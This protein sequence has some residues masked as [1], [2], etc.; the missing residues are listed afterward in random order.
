MDRDASPGGELAPGRSF[1][2][3]GNLH[4]RCAVFGD[5]G[6]KNGV[7]GLPRERTGVKLSEHILLGAGAALILSPVLHQRSLA[8]FAASV[9]LDVDHY[10]HYVQFTGWRDWSPRRMFTFNELISSMARRP[11]FLGLNTCHTIEFFLLL[12]LSAS[13]LNSP[14]LMAALA[15]GLFHMCLD[16]VEHVQHG[17]TWARV[18]SILEYVIRRRVMEKRGLH[19]EQLFREVAEKVVSDGR[20]AT[21][22]APGCGLPCG[23]PRPSLP[24]PA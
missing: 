17:I 16:V 7:P 14:L 23:L 6:P 3:T 8:F 20:P 19:P 5:R 24:G 10:W 18:Y 21:R 22:T 4:D 1:T 11:D 12:Y 13:D 2:P 9:L 15:G